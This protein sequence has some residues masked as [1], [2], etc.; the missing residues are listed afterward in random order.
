[1]FVWFY[2]T[3]FDFTSHDEFFTAGAAPRT[4][5]TVR[6]EQGW[7]ATATSENFL[8]LKSVTCSVKEKESVEVVN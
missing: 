6:E 5:A 8:F 2:L 4:P 3:L 7:T 1:M